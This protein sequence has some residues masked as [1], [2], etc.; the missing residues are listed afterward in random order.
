MERSAYPF[1]D[2]DDD[3][4]NEIGQEG[5]NET[6]SLE[7]DE[8]MGKFIFPVLQHRNIAYGSLE[9]EQFVLCIA[10]SSVSNDVETHQGYCSNPP[11]SFVK[12]LKDLPRCIFILKRSPFLMVLNYACIDL[13][14]T[15]PAVFQIKD[16]D[17][18]WKTIFCKHNHQK[19]SLEYS[20]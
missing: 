1:N 19:D 5:I 10:F 15:F 13:L 12:Y 11:S 14:S 17:I 7:I 9:H 4:D 3:C 18:S 2:F 6:D 20:R 8:W 16:V